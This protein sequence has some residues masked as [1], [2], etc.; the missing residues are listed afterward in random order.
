MTLSRAYADLYGIE[1]IILKDWG[2]APRPAEAWREV[3]ELVHTFGPY[4]RID[5]CRPNVL[6]A[7]PPGFRH[8]AIAVAVEQSGGWGL[9]CGAGDGLGRLRARFTRA[10]EQVVDE[11]QETQLPE[12]PP[13]SSRGQVRYAS[14][15]SC[16]EKWHALVPGTARNAWTAACPHV[17]VSGQKKSQK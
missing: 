14:G 16:F 6:R 13:N 5:H 8:P 12:S 4:A 11:S 10:Y 7:G 17:V 1:K 3:V 15:F 9:L 2:M